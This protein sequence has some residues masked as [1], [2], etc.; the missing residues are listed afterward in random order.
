MHV[1]MNEAFIHSPQIKLKVG[2]SITS[3]NFNLHVGNAAN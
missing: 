2:E 3:L 1:Q